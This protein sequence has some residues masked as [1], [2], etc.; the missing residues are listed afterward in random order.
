MMTEEGSNE[1]QLWACDP[2]A[3]CYW[4]KSGRIQWL[5]Q[6]PQLCPQRPPLHVFT[7]LPT[8]LLVSSSIAL[9]I[10]NLPPHP[11][12]C[13][14]DITGALLCLSS[15]VSGAAC[16]VAE[17]QLPSVRLP[18]RANKAVPAALDPILGC[19]ADSPQVAHSCCRCRPKAAGAGA[20]C[21]R[22]PALPPDKAGAALPC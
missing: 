17:C 20:F 6:G 2:G 5:Q 13:G 11:G 16:A 8:Q 12:D 10:P 7:L 22:L 3:L 4:C 9:P 18:C 1:P 19:D 21:P 14:Q 15:D